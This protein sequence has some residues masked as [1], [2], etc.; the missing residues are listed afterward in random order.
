LDAGA[1]VR[2]H[3]LPSVL[4][5]IRIYFPAGS[6]FGGF[7]TIFRVHE[8]YALLKP[9]Y[10]NHAHNDWLEILLDGGLPAALLLVVALGWW[11]R[12][13]IRVWRASAD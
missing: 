1:D 13:S 9:T 8:P 11:L 3:A 10:F 2:V 5:M 12:A 4:A 6:G 7:D